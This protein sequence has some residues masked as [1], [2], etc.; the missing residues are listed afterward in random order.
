MNDDYLKMKD[1]YLEMSRIIKD[2]DDHMDW[3]S[4]EVMSSF[5]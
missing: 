2:I 1:D 5:R 4:E 3:L